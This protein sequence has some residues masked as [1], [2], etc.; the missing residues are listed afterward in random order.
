MTQLETAQRREREYMQ[1]Q[2]AEYSAVVARGIVPSDYAMLSLDDYRRF[3]ADCTESLAKMPA[4]HEAERAKR[5]AILAAAEQG[6]AEGFMLHSWHQTRKAADAKAR[7]LNADGWTRVAI[8]PV[9]AR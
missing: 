3:V 6:K 7:S 9:D 8:Y 2:L 4:R 1:K 5:A